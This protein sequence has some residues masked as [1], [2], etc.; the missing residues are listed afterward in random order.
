MQ[1][2]MLQHFVSQVKYIDMCVYATLNLVFLSISSTIRHY[3][4][5]IQMILESIDFHLLRLY[6][7]KQF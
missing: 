3:H 1:H 7:F 6:R 5:F 4:T 2:P